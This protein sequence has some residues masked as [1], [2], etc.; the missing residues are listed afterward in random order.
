MTIA[1]RAALGREHM[2]PVAPQRPVKI[3][4]FALIG[5]TVAVLL[6]PSLSAAQHQ[7][8]LPKGLASRLVQQAHRPHDVLLTAPQSEIDRL[9]AT[10]GVTV[11]SR[12]GFGALLRGSSAQIQAMAGDTQVSALALNEAVFSTM[13]VTT[14]ATG[15]NQLW[16]A[17]GDSNFFGGLTGRGVGVAVIDSGVAAHPDIDGRVVY[18]KDFTTEGTNADG[19][20]HG[21]HVAGTI[22]G[23]GGG[24][25]SADGT[26][27]VGMAP[28]ANI[29]ALRVLGSDGTGYVADVIAAIEWCLQNKE[30]R[31]IRVINLSL[32]H[33]P[34]SESRDDP[35]AQ[36]VERAVAE[37]IVVVASA[38]NHGK[39][40]DG[41]PVVGMVVSPGFTPSALTVGAL[42]TRATV[43][44]SDDG[45][46]TYS[47]RGPVGDSDDPSGWLVK[48][49]VVAPGNSIVAAGAE[50]SALWE[51]LADRRVTGVS[52]GTYLKLSGASMATAV[53]AGAAAQLLQARPRLTPAEVKFALQYTASP[54]AGFGLMDQGA[55]SINVALAAELVSIGYA[56]AAP[57]TNIIGNETVESGQVWSQTVGS[58]TVVWGARG[59][60]AVGGDTVVWG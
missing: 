41:N 31:N 23:N 51:K 39:D 30:R 5:T 56:D 55:G 54:L 48:P 8:R 50:G 26:T 6:C 28:G 34:T 19:F 27:Y 59:G 21:T 22:A 17:R 37:G 15:A 3:R 35:M 14:Q 57:T 12:Y 32:G 42:N 13:A 4:A 38:G 25:R 45:V 2:N 40:E 58:S 9:A 10:Y 29:I 47:S 33:V 1:S 18:R 43:A 46:A 24:S 16:Q 44:R 7:A 60:G 36:A 53:T 20:G 49:D 52:G 11:R